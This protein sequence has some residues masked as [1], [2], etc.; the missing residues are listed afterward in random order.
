MIS[1][2]EIGV[3]RSNWEDQSCESFESG[4]VTSSLRLFQDW[5]AAWMVRGSAED[6]SGGGAAGCR[7]GVPAKEGED[8][9]SGGEDWS[10]EFS[11]AF[12]DDGAGVGGEV[13]GGDGAAGGVKDADCSGEA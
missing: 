4:T 1:S 9:G 6:V 2:S 10:W 13:S 8:S 5:G 12:G 7:G 3:C 11:E